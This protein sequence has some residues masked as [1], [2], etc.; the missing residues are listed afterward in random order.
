[1]PITGQGL[2]GITFSPNFHDNTQ[3]GYRKFYTFQV[4]TGPGGANIMF[5]HPEVANPGQVGV[6]REW[7]ANTRCRH[8][9]VLQAV[10]ER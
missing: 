2:Q 3:P 6:L 9:S 4:E 1:M 7:T 5:L 8:G 10:L